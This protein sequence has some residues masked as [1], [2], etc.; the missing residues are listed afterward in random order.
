MM[1]D[2]NL[3]LSKTA[4]NSIA[5]LKHYFGTE[6]DAEIIRKALTLLKIAKK[7]D[8][9]HGQLIAKKGDKESRIVIR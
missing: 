7:I 9:T 5:E 1:S 8:E 3:N 2:L 6:S 4:V